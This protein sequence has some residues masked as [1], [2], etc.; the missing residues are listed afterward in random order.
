MSSQVDESVLARIPTEV[1][2][3]IETTQGATIVGLE[4]NPSRREGWIV[5]LKAPSGETAERFL[6]LDRDTEPGSTIREARVVEVLQDHGVPVAGLFVRDEELCTALYTRAPGRADLNNAPAAEQRAVFEHFIEILAD[7]HRLDPQAMELDDVLEWPSS[8]TEAAMLEVVKLQT[9]HRPEELE[10]PLVTFGIEWLLR[11]VPSSMD[12]VALLQGDTGPANFLFSDHRVTAVIDWE[13]A[14]FGD[15]MEDL[16]NVAYRNIFH[17]SGDLREL[18]ALYGAKVGTPVALDRI[19]YYRAQQAVRSAIALARMTARNDPNTP[20]ALNLAYR[21]INDR[22]AC[23]SMAEAIGLVVAR[24]DPLVEEEEHHDAN[25]F[26][27]VV[28]D[29]LEREI[30]PLLGDDWSR[31]RLRDVSVLVRCIDRQLRFAQLF[32]ERDLDELNAL[33]GTGH[34]SL[35]EGLRDLNRQVSALMATAEGEVLAYLARRAYRA[36]ELFEPAVDLFPDRRLSPFA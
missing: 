12:R 34:R 10:E 28:V 7:W 30:L 17:P 15:P 21:L 27:D 23:E 3:W 4:R 11:H 31:Y 16:G 13:W 5:T 29:N 6:R 22:I 24:P 20:V 19:Y 14:H 18:F 8:P 2:E 32:E 35:A 25:S 33:L 9:T 36:E 26:S 1:A